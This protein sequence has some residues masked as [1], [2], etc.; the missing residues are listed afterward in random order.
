MNKLPKS[1]HRYFWD[2]DPN[3]LDPQRYRLYVIRR[4]FE[5]GDIAALRWIFKRYRRSSL[6]KALEGR[7][8]SA[9]ARAFWSCYLKHQ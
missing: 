7:D 5:Y 2:I 9:R 4:I 1:L 6:S 3:K 8:L